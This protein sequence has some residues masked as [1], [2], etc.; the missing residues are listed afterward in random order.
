MVLDWRGTLERTQSENKKNPALV[1]TSG[2]TGCCFYHNTFGEAADLSS[3][4]IQS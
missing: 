4:S 1:E 2:M 3:L